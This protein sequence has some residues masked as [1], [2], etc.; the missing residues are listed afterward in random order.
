[1]Q[2]LCREWRVNKETKSKYMY[3]PLNYNY[4]LRN[5]SWET[6]EVPE[7]VSL[8]YSTPKMSTLA[9]TYNKFHIFIGKNFCKSLFCRS[10]LYVTILCIF[11]H[12]LLFLKV[13][14]AVKTKVFNQKVLENRFSARLF[15]SNQSISSSIRNDDFLLSEIAVEDFPLSIIEIIFTSVHVYIE[16]GVN[17]WTGWNAINNWNAMLRLCGFRLFL[18][19]FI[20]Y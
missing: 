5:T 15:E 11:I 10:F 7:L 2:T 12:L 4:T 18:E 9:R 13:C 6:R 14:F 8:L 19:T 1:M 16:T 3:A 20:K 17:Q